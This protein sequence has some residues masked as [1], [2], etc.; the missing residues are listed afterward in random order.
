[1]KTNPLK[2]RTIL[3][4]TDLQGNNSPALRYGQAI[5]HQH[6]STLVILYVIDPVG[7][8]FPSGSPQ[9]LEANLEAYKELKRVEEDLRIAGIT[10]HSVVESGVICDRILQAVKDHDADLLILSTKAR[11]SAGRVALGTIARRLLARCSCP[12]LTVPPE[13]E[14]ILSTA[15]CWRRVLVAIDFSAASLAALQC[16][17]AIVRGQLLVLHASN[18]E[19]EQERATCLEKLRF[20]APL[21]ESHTVPVEHIAATGDIS[22]LIS[23]QTLNFG[24]DLIVLGAPSSELSSEEL[25]SSTVLEVISEAVCPVLCVPATETAS[26]SRPLKDAVSV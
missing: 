24:P 3:L 12:I 7:Y 26:S 11:T 21:N 16:A 20:L 2:F 4:A 15:G 23:Q 13:A 25:N 19:N 9:F 14:S 8:A 17:H 5:A 10:V 22:T 18:A 6:G 1:M